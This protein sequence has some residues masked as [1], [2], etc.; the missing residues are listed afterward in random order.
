[1]FLDNKYTKWYYAIVI[2]AKIK[3]LDKKFSEKHHIIPRCLGGSNELEN[4][5]RLSYKQHFICHLLLTK[6]TEGDARSK[7]LYTMW[8][9][10]GKTKK[11]IARA[12]FD[13]QKISSR[14]F[15]YFKRLRK[16]LG[17]STETRLKMSKGMMGK[18]KNKTASIE[19]KKK[20]SEAAKYRITSKETKNKISL[21]VSNEWKNGIRSNVG[22]QRVETRLKNGWTPPM[23]GRKHS[24]ET[25]L[26][27]S[28]AR[29][30]NLETCIS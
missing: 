4:I 20:M 3:K 5:V 16:E 17:V 1:M 19:T 24:V 7:M 6:M 15:Q 9:F 2:D 21:R 14:W 26:K 18:N 13:V 25:K 30:K 27:M 29:R 11:Q 12:Q 8:L 23:T 10:R 22:K 28:I